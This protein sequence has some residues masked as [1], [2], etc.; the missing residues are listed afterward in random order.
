MGPTVP[1]AL[2]ARLKTLPMNA[3]P[4]FLMM[5]SILLA[6]SST[7]AQAE[8]ERVTLMLNGAG[9]Q[10]LHERIEE[11]FRQ[12]EGVRTVDSR[13]ISGHL[14][15]DIERGSITAE[16]LARHASEV[17]ATCRADVMATCITAGA[18]KVR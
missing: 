3:T 8:S 15:I 4:L 14:L 6:P 9:C 10:T 16:E 2:P 12:L 13:S 5:I 7:W 18:V 11:V 17:A 1:P